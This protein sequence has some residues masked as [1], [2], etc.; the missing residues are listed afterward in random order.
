LLTYRIMRQSQTGNV[1]HGAHR[2]FGTLEAIQSDRDLWLRGGSVT[3]AA[4]MTHSDIYVLPQDSGDLPDEPPVRTNWAR[5]GTLTEGT[6]VFVSGRLRAE[7]SHAVMYGDDDD[8]L[9]VVLYDGPDRT[10]LRRSIWSGRQL[11]EYWN[12][13]TPAALAGGT[14][15]LITMAYVLLRASAGRLPAIAGLTMASIP[16][17]PLLPPGVAFF[18]L[19]RWSWRRGRFLRAHRDI[20]RL[21]LRYFADG[22]HSGVLPDGEP[23]EVRSVDPDRAV[24]LERLGAHYVE[25]PV[26]SEAGAYAVFGRPD[27]DDL[28]VPSDPM[29][30]MVVIPGDPVELSERCQRQARAYELASAGLFGLALLLNAGVVF[31]VLQYVV[32]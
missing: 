9:L 19:Y 22:A 6:K 14:L 16:L 8:P 13:L 18:F 28:A 29:I 24:A 10:L 32:R 30:E 7:G 2:F 4:N 26:R 15:A 23:Y 31:V 21:P 17:I 25:P 27:G 11:N 5:L 3:V 1:S 20:L 12:Q